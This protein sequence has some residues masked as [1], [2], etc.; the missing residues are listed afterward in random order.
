MTFKILKIFSL[1]ALL[2]LAGAGIAG[3]AFWKGISSPAALPGQEISFEVPAGAGTRRI[4]QDLE[5]FGLIRSRRYFEIYLWLKGWE[6]RLK[7]GEHHLHSS[8]NIRQIARYLYSGETIDQSV[9]IKIIEGWNNKEIADYLA[10]A[11][12]PAGKGFLDMSLGDDAL[13]QGLSQKYSALLADKPPLAGLEGYMFPDTYFAYKDARPEDIISK[14]LANLDQ[15]LDPKMRE[16]IKNRQKSIFEILIM[17]S[18]IQKEVAN[19]SDMKMVSGIFWNRLDIGQPLQSCATLAYLLGEN[20]RQYSY[21]DTRTPSPYNTYMNRGLPPGP[22]SNPGLE[23]IS[24]AIYPED[25]DYNYFLSDPETGKTVFS[26][27]LDEHNL[28][29]YKYLK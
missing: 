26:R 13:P 28:N 24:A 29:K 20:K 14:M 7:A 3:L 16:D 4:S 15:K 12:L 19:R 25:N 18:I 8:G 21:E 5:A 1:S 6:G 27:T 22:I 23:A 11:G 10:G 9:K 17:A 2:L